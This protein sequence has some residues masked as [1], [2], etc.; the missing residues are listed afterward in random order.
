MIKPFRQ[1]L[2]ELEATFRHLEA[3]VPPPVMIP[4]KGG[5]VL[6]YNEKTPLQAILQKFARQISGLHAI[7]LLLEHGFCQEQG[8]IQR[9]LD[10][11]EEDILF[12][13]LGLSTGEWTAHHILYLKHFWSEEPGSSMVKRDKIRAY[14]NRAS[15]LAD[16]ST[17]NDNGRAIFKAYSG[18]VHANSITIVDMC[19]GDP[20][21]YHLAGMVN[22][23]L[24]IDH[25]N[26]AWNYFYRGLT[27]AVVVAKAF[28]DSALYAQR[29]ASLKAF[30]K[31][32]SQRIFPDSNG[33]V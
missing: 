13:T 10:D 3:K 7:G 15:G 26:D 14:V 6:R 11:I 20:P 25:A 1:V 33:S 18:Y 16:P 22:N 4:H 29:F 5:F 28:E 27:S 19:M 24:Y 30:E 2:G 21:R 17:A 23:P 32:F 8:V 31:E 12:I 9:T